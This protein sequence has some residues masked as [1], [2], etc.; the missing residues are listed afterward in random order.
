MRGALGGRCPWGDTET[1]PFAN[2]C[3][4]LSGGGVL[5]TIRTGAPPAASRECRGL[6]RSPWRACRLNSIAG[7]SRGAV[8]CPAVRAAEMGR[9][10]IRVGLPVLR[11]CG[12]CVW[13]A[14][15]PLGGI[16][17]GRSVHGR[18]CSVPCGSQPPWTGGAAGPQLARGHLARRR[19]Q[20]SYSMGNLH[21]R[22]CQQA[23][24][25]RRPG[26]YLR[27]KWQHADGRREDQHQ[28]QPE[29]AGRARV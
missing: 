17:I 5:P 10:A 14:N 4:L 2:P 9:Q 15:Q 21:I 28:G 24:H 25:P 11:C 12:P 1:P 7:G 27:P 26:V 16:S 19:S 22:P 13:L 29:W 6:G 20:D 18:L 8:A 3:A 23:D